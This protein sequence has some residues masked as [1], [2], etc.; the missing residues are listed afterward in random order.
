MFGFGIGSIRTRFIYL[1]CSRLPRPVRVQDHPSPQFILCITAF[2]VFFLCIPFSLFG[3]LICFYDA[4]YPFPTTLPSP[5]PLL[6]KLFLAARPRLLHSSVC[7]WPAEFH[8]RVWQ[9]WVG[10]ANGTKDVFSSVQR[11]KIAPPS[12]SHG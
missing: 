7:V 8:S 5:L 6:L 12:S 3:S 9:A 10:V 4:V 1:C 11:K 2:L